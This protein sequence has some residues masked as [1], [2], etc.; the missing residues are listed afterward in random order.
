MSSSS[1]SSKLHSLAEIASRIRA[2]S[3]CLEHSDESLD[4]ENVGFVVDTARSMDEQLNSSAESSDPLQSKELRHDLRNLV[5]VI[6]GFSDLM[7]ME[8]TEG[9]PEAQALDEIVELSDR[10][11]SELDQVKEFADAG[12]GTEVFQ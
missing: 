6:R 9:G 2:S 5:S 10:F 7:R 8:V 12:N 11:V 4:P 3:F 1:C